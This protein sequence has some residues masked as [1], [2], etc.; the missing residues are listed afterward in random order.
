VCCGSGHCWISAAGGLSNVR[1]GSKL[2]LRG[3]IDPRPE[4]GVEPKQIARKLTFA[5][6]CPKL[7]VFS[8]LADA[9]SEREVLAKRRRRAGSRHSLWSTFRGPDYKSK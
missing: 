4:L 3:A 6:E 5:L 2:P 8:P 9:L 1:V 7:E